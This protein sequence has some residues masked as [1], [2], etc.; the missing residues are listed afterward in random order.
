MFE[1]SNKSKQVK[2]LSLHYIRQYLTIG[3]IPFFESKCLEPTSGSPNGLKVNFRL[4]LS[5]KMH[6]PSPMIVRTRNCKPGREGYDQIRSIAQSLNELIETHKNKYH[7]GF[8]I[9]CGSEW[10]DMDSLLEEISFT[11]V[12]IFS[13]N[14]FVA[15]I[16][17]GKVK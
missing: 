2:E 11:H 12:K 7:Q 17:Q 14:K 10:Q 8:V 3:K 13:V 5:D 16:V 1:T 4:F 15:Q 9:I 6:R